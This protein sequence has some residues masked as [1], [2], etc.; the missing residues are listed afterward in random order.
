MEVN[1]EPTE[2]APRKMISV[3]IPLDMYEVLKSKSNSYDLSV[4]QIIR[5][6]IKYFLKQGMPV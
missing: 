6:S 2:V 3:K 1:K 5:R 4:A